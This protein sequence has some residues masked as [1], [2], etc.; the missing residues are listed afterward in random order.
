[1]VSSPVVRARWMLVA[2]SWERP[3]PGMLRKRVQDRP[4]CGKLPDGL[5]LIKIE[6]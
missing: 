6:C 1:M 5:A 4:R 3:E 2:S